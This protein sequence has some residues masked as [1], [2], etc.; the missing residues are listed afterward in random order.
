MKWCTLHITKYC[1]PNTHII[2]NA[3]HYK[4]LYINTHI[5]YNVVHYKILYPNTFW[6]HFED[7]LRA[8]YIVNCIP[9]NRK[10]IKYQVICYYI[11]AAD[12][13][14]VVN[15]VL[16]DVGWPWMSLDGAGWRCTTIGERFGWRWMT[17]WITLD[18][19]LDN[20]GWRFGWRMTFWITLDDGLDDDGWRFGW[21]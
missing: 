9:L 21:R 14:D 19:V 3:V 8:I 16:D 20:V 6:G 5:A 11:D 4:L 17:F 10:W 2:W 13:L 12:V 18:D 7:L 1:I 15:D